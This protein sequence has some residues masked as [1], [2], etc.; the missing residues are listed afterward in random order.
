MAEKITL[1]E[2]TIDESGAITSLKKIEKQAEN[3]SRKGSASFG[4]FQATVA[5]FVGNL[6]A[7]A[8]SRAWS[9]IVNQVSG[10]VKAAQDLE[11][12]RTQFQ[13][14]LGSAS[15]AEAQLKSLQQFAATTPFQIEG[16]A[17]ATRQLLS[18]GV[19]QED[20]IPTLRK[21]GDLAAGVGVSIDQ[22]TIPYG[23]LIST[24]KLTLIELDKFADRGINLFG[25]LSKETGI[26]LKIIRDEISKGKVSFES[27]TK[28]F[29]GLTEEGG[30]FFNAMDAQSKTLTGVLSTLDDN[31]FNL[32]ATI[33]QLASPSIVTAVSRLTEFLQ[34]LNAEIVGGDTEKIQE[35]SVNIRKMNDGLKGL[36]TTLDNIKEGKQGVFDYVFYGTGDA[37]TIEGRI[38][39]TKAR[40]AELNAERK[41]LLDESGGGAAGGGDAADNRVEL[42]ETTVQQIAQIR[43]D[44]AIAE[45]ESK[46]LGIEAEEEAYVGEL[47][48][49]QS[50]I[51]RQAEIRRTAI[52]NTVKDENVKA[53]MLAKVDADLIN[54]RK[55]AQQKAIQD[56]IRA[57][58][59]L[60]KAKIG[61]V[62][63]TGDAI[64]ALTGDNAI[65]GLA[66]SKTMAVA[67][68][69]IDKARA[70]TGALAQSRMLPVGFSEGYL[71]QAL[72]TNQALFGVSLATIAAQTVA[73]VSRFRDGGVVGGFGATGP[74]DT[75]LTRQTRGEMDL[76]SRQQRNLF[77]Q[78]N[79]PG[80][81]ATNEDILGAIASI[82]NR[83]LIVEIDGR[84]VARAYRNAQRDGYAA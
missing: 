39:N 7:T 2:A 27:F 47:E 55:A 70:D 46:L 60:S 65:A 43:A 15:A 28:V 12:Y 24:Q 18:F 53:E 50:N 49:F 36:E 33:G 30:T 71:A 82:A 56:Q 57:E 13:T 21:V 23:R 62:A 42:E 68:A 59:G 75:I 34:D 4:T 37:A 61:L 79:M 72:S 16:L 73:Q 64:I 19:V 69:W 6:A 3:T 74:A 14:I 76:N 58:Q 9:G 35:I 51:D 38:E 45:E 80:D 63:A 1:L 31:F 20:I 22:L 17:L 44:A 26:S 40:I 48:R 5:S 77:N 84:E 78:L 10:V 52:E 81:G 83:P 25:A 29:N 41:K 67:Q 66:F 8:A 32:Q 54:K 11:V